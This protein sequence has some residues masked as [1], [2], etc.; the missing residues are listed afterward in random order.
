MQKKGRIYDIKCIVKYTMLSLLIVAVWVTYE[1]TLTDL[2][3]DYVILPLLAPIKRNIWTAMLLLSMVGWCIYDM[4]KRSKTKFIYHPNLIFGILWSVIICGYYRI[5]GSYIFEPLIWKITYVDVILAMGVLYVMLA[6]VNWAKAGRA[7]QLNNQDTISQEDPDL[8]L[9]VPIE[10]IDDDIM[11]WEGEIEKVKKLVRRPVGMRSV[12]IAIN[13][14]WGSGKTSFLNIVK[15]SIDANEFNVIYFNPRDSKSVNEIQEDF[16]RQ[17]IA[18]LEKYDGRAKY[19]V[20][21]YMTALQLIDDS[22]WLYKILN[23]YNEWNK[24]SAKKRI[25][26][27]CENLPRKIL[28]IIDDFDRLRPDEIQEILKLIDSNASFS[29]FVYLT[30]YD[31]QVVCKILADYDHSDIANFTDKYFELEYDLP[32][33]P[34]G[35]IRDYF[36]DHL[37]QSMRLVESDRKAIEKEMTEQEDLF[38]VLIPTIRDAKRIVNLMAI[39]NQ[40]VRNEVYAREYFYV[41][42][43]KYKYPKE[44]KDLAAGIYTESNVLKSFNALFLKKEIAESKDIQSVPILKNL[45][46]IDGS[47]RGSLYRHIYEEPSFEYYFTNKL[48]DSLM[49]N[50]MKRIFEGDEEEMRSLID[51]WLKNDQQANDFSNYMQ[52]LNMANLGSKEMFMRYASAAAYFVTKSKGRHGN[53]IVSRLLYK[54]NIDACV[55]KYALDVD[56]YKSHMINMLSDV[57]IDPHLSILRQLH[58]TYQNNAKDEQTFIIKDADIW[59]IVKIRFLQILQ[60]QG[61]ISEEDVYRYLQNCID[62]LDNDRSVILDKDCCAAYRKHLDEK[63]EY[64]VK[65]FVRLVMESSVSDWNMIGCEPFWKQIFADIKDLEQFAKI[66]A[67]INVTNGKRMQ[68]FVE[69]FDANGCEPIEYQHQGDVQKIIDADLEEEVEKLHRLQEIDER[70]NQL[71]REKH[72]EVELKMEL[73]SLK[74]T[75]DKTKLPIYYRLDLSNRLGEKIKVLQ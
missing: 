17:V 42:L 25:I 50:E 72:D 3:R 28:V 46:A 1:T 60:N 43:M 35:Y 36:V 4:V 5:K 65:N 71:T 39:D 64:Y 2:Y 68:N 55:Q 24:N 53:I 75:L 9:D 32:I 56:V 27:I 6:I 31:K 51:T 38:R 20:R 37:A 44:Y 73:S 10:S 59:H 61:E 26:E 12:G 41:H 8:L 69:I 21:R 48:Y 18:T 7:N 19:L 54:E 58:Y 57:L 11:D 52:F 74:Q 63:P 66:C 40:Y 45:F 67:E 23:V 30:A 16:F 49:I 29:N 62:H 33:R 70:L 15:K 22:S 13:A 14:P 47:Y 34:Y